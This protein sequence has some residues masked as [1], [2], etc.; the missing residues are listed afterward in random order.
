MTLFRSFKSRLT[1][2]YALMMTVFLA[3]F[4]FLMY[5]E[6][7]RT[8]Y[9]DVER[10]MYGEA[11]SIEGGITTSFRDYEILRFSAPPQSKKGTLAFPEEFQSDIAKAIREWE[12]KQRRVT[13]SLFFVRIVGLDR[14][15]IESNLGGWER[16]IL[17]PDYERDS[18]L[19]EKGDSYQTIHFEKNPIRLYYHLARFQG[20][21]FFII[22]IA[23]PL[24]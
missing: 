8:L 10:S 20:R 1:L 2:G 19:M 17:F 22:Q 6:L 13:R 5:V 18:V 14:S 12:K 3:G 16:D 9:R 21:P 7:S 23:K 4:A 11:Q 15:V 24:Y